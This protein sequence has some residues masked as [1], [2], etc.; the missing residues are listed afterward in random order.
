MLDVKYKD[1]T[2]GEFRYR[3]E[4]NPCDGMGSSLSNCIGRDYLARATPGES[5]GAISNSLARAAG[6]VGFFRSFLGRGDFHRFLLA[7]HEGDL[8]FVRR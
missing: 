5:P 8:L 6:Q 3:K 7:R 1:G 2:L 4:K